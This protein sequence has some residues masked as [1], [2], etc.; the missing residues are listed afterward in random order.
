M[1]GYG[2]DNHPDP[3]LG[4]PQAK[5][6]IER[7]GGTFHDRLVS[8]SRLGREPRLARSVSRRGAAVRRRQRWSRVS[9][10]IS[11]TCSSSSHVPGLLAHGPDDECHRASVSRGAPTDAPNELLHERGEL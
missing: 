8:E 2:D 11:M 5:G 3:R 1:S 9:R 6:R 4:S 7:V 10:R